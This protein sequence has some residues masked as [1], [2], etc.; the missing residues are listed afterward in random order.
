MTRLRVIEM[1]HSI[2]LPA[3][4]E[5]QLADYCKAHQVTEEEAIARAIEELVRAAKPPTPYELGAAGFG[6]DRTHSGDIAKNSK[7][8]L[9]ERFGGDGTR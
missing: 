7:R 4:I 3:A 5:A 2:E 6:A 1:T 9:R 8:L